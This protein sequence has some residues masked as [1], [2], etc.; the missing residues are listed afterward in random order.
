MNQPNPENRNPADYLAERK[1][2]ALAYGLRRSEALGLRWDA[3]DFER[4]TITIRHIVT[5]AK[6][7]GKYEI[8]RED[9]AKT[10]SSL[11]SL[12]L[13]DNIREKLLALKKLMIW[14]CAISLRQNP[15][16]SSTSVFTTI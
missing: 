4:N 3:I 8:V 11:R 12:P 9:R 13:V 15:R 14:M 2:F 7:D 6:I 10:K 16:C 5:N 1:G